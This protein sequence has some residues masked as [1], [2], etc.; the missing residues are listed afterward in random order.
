MRALGA[1]VPC[2]LVAVLSG[3]GGESTAPSEPRPAPAP[4]PSAPAP[5]VTPPADD[6]AAGNN[7]VPDAGMID[8]DEFVYDE[9]IVDD[10]YEQ[11]EADAAAL[12]RDNGGEAALPADFPDDIQLPE[13]FALQAATG[14]GSEMFVQGASQQSAGD[15]AS[16]FLQGMQTTGWT[17]ADQ[18]EDSSPFHQK[19]ELTFS[20]DG[21]AVVVSIISNDSLAD[22]QVT[23]TVQ[24]P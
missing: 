19:Y 14:G 3:C 11:L 8:P 1:M 12:R 7:A 10:L 6:E 15:L 22:Q 24:D 21:R 2:L 23:L 16:H 4:P 9:T 13:D 5:A 20:K 17:L 18:S